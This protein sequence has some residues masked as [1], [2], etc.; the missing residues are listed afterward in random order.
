M[1]NTRIHWRGFMPGKEPERYTLHIRGWDEMTYPVIAPFTRA[2]NE[3]MSTAVTG[4]C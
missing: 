4:A 3:W 2:I 1:Q